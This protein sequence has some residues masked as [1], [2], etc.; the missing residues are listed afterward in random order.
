MSVINS[1]SMRAGASGVV[2]GYVI[3]NSCRFNDDDSAYMYRTPSIAGNRKT[4]TYSV[5]FKRGNM[6][7]IQT[8]LNA[9]ASEDL[10]INASDQLIMNMGTCSYISTQLFRDPSAWYHLVVATDTTQS[11]ASSRVR[12][13]LNGTEITAFGT[14]TNP[15][16]N[17]DLAVNSATL[18]SIGANEGGTE[19]WDGYLADVHFIDGAVSTAA[20]FGETDTNG[21]WVPIEYDATITTVTGYDQSVE[22]GGTIGW[23]NET[24][25][26]RG[27]AIPNN[28]VVKSIGWN[29]SVAESAAVLYISERTSSTVYTTKTSIAANHTGSGWEFFDLASEYTVPATGTHYVG[30]FSGTGG[31]TT[32]RGTATEGR[33]DGDGAASQTVGGTAA[34]TEGSNGS[35]SLGVKYEDGTGYGTNGFRLDFANSSSFGLDASSSGDVSAVADKDSEE[36]EWNG[37]TGAYTFGTGNIDRSTTVNAIRSNDIL[38]GN[39]LI[40]F[41]LT[42]KGTG[43]RLGVYDVSEDGAFI[44]SGSDHGGMANMT[45]SWVYDVG[46]AQYRYGGSNQAAESIANGSV[47]TFE[48]TG[49]TIKV[50]DDGAGG[51]TWSQT[52]SGPIRICLAGGGSAYALDS[53]NWTSASRYGNSYSD[54]GLATNDQMSDSPTDDSANDVGNYP[55]L[56][57]LWPTQTVTYTDG[58]LTY[59]RSGQHA[60]TLA[61]QAIPSTGKWCFQ[62][63]FVG[64]PDGTAG[65]GPFSTTF[66]ANSALETSGAG[67][68]VSQLGRV[69]LLGSQFVDGTNFSNDEYA[70]ICYDA[71]N[72]KAWAG[73]STGGAWAWY[74]SGDPA[75]G[76]GGHDISSLDKPLF[77][78]V[79]TEG[80]VS[81]EF[82]KNRFVDVTD[83]GN[84]KS[85]CTANLPAPAISDPSAHFQATAYTGNGTAIGS[86]GKEVNQ[87]G[88]STFTPDFVWIKNR[89][90][91]DQHILTDIARGVTKYLSSDGQ[92]VEVTDA[93][94]LS[95]FDADGFTVGNDVQVNTNTEDYIAWQW[96]AGGGAGSSN[97]A[98]SINT[99]TTTVNTTA[100]CSLSTYTGDGNSGATIG[101]G[102]G[103]A[104]DFIIIKDRTNE[105]SWAVF[106]SK[107]TDAPET[108]FLKLNLTNATEDAIDRWND[109]LPSS[110]LITLGNNTAVNGSSRT[111]SAWAWANVEGFSKFGTYIGNTST[112]GPFI[113]CGFRPSLVIIKT[114][115]A[116]SDWYMF[117]VKRDPINLAGIQLKPNATDAETSQSVMDILSNGFK[118]RHADTAYNNTGGLIFAA[119]AENPFGGDGVAQARAR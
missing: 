84:F 64:T 14:E 58:N 35:F 12:F 103:V 117:D 15:A 86:G 92:D 8:L 22:A 112:A 30:V 94:T 10:A 80:T 49:S 105:N 61:T 70:C 2:S 46:N 63:K 53:F 5:W 98:G 108:D 73:I 83:L 28:K 26:D 1:D 45:N 44:T 17:E 109:T 115:T 19:E 96:L 55:T 25:W 71:D 13:Y 51:H 20:S 87:G 32:T 66:A 111:Y 78:G 41:T 40:D 114:I 118:I 74:D 60:I 29:S 24:I 18:H 34:V 102:I 69:K 97:T 38:T 77:F 65:I 99:T 104:P 7:S 6:G 36:G 89:D 76:S 16:Q 85:L 59:T 91:S 42:T 11:T 57:P 43:M 90:A 106:H 88:S 3:S 9:G 54:S 68:G 107:N 47:V 110:T 81:V 21:V 50:T 95:T 33:F 67:Y 52:Y 56:S 62:M 75:A 113:W 82:D 48:R 31:H 72:E 101:H 93:E 119:W 79:S 100:G 39:F 23:T 27:W 37:T 4:W 116:G